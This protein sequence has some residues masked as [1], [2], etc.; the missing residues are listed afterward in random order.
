MSYIIIRL[1]FYSFILPLLL[2]LYIKI[3]T[4]QHKKILLTSD[5]ENM[6]KYT[7]LKCKAISNQ[8]YFINLIEESVHL[9]I[10]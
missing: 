8:T 4:F 9:T 7:F 2:F 5:Y 6:L 3:Q 10:F 1:K